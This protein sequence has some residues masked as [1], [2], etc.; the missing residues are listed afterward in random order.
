M[1]DSRQQVPQHPADTLRG[2]HQRLAP[3][4]ALQ[5]ILAITAHRVRERQSDE[6][7]WFDSLPLEMYDWKTESYYGN[8]NSIDGLLLSMIDNFKDAFE[9][10]GRAVE[11]REEWEQANREE[12]AE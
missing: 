10:L 7:A 11:R 4:M 9:K 12:C 2:L 8:I 1:S 6:H 5:E 3:A